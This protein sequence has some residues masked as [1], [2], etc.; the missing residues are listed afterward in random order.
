MQASINTVESISSD[1]TVPRNDIEKLILDIWREVLKRDDIDIQ[2]KFLESGGDSFKSLVVFG[3]LRR[4]F[5][6]LTVAQLFKY[7]SIESLAK[8]LGGES[9]APNKTKVVQL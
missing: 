8:E 7:P 6:N 3:R 9:T 1:V 4:H 2:A 5:P